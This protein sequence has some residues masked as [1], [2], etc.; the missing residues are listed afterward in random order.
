M[1]RTHRWCQRKLQSILWGQLAAQWQREVVA[2]C[3]RE[4]ARNVEHF[5]DQSETECVKTRRRKDELDLSNEM[6]RLFDHRVLESE[7]HACNNRQHHLSI[8][9]IRIV[10][11]E[12]RKGQRRFRERP[13][14]V[15]WRQ[16]RK[17]PLCNQKHHQNEEHP[18]GTPQR[19]PNKSQVPQ[20]TR[21]DQETKKELTTIS[22]RNL[23]RS[24]Q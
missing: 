21:T 18:R 19:S 7:A 5:L 3:L 20:Q 9:Q 4:G 6:N 23:L 8:V 24:A 15:R 1:L 10:L 16:S 22:L 2:G 17:V 14:K 12:L 11:N 13:E